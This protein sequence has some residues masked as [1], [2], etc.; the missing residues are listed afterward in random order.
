MEIQIHFLDGTSLVNTRNT[1]ANPNNITDYSK[2][3]A[4]GDTSSDRK[5]ITD[6]SMSVQCSG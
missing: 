2:N 1:M 6:Q 4:D 3:Y 5:T